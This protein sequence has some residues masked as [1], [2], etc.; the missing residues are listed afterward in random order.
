MDGWH[1]SEWL[2]DGSLVG[3]DLVSRIC[4]FSVEFSVMLG[5]VCVVF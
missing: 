2:F 1:V 4:C 5:W 3:W